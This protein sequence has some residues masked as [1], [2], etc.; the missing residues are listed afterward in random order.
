MSN[1]DN[2]KLLLGIDIGTSSIK[3]S[4][5]DRELK[6]YYSNAVKYKYDT[7]N[8]DWTEINPAVWTD[9]IC[10][11]LLKIFKMPFSKSIKGICPTAQMHTLVFLNE[12]NAPIRKAIMWN[13]KRTKN[14]ITDLKVALGKKLDFKYNANIISTGS[15]LANLIWLKENE[16]NNFKRLKKICM[17]K[18]Y[19][20]TFL[21][22]KIATDFCDASVSCLMDLEK[23]K[24]SKKIC[25]YFGI[26]IGILPNI[27]KSTEQVGL[28][29]GNI[30][31]QLS[32]KETIPVFTGTGDN[33]ATV[34]ATKYFEKTKLVLSLGTSGVVLTENKHLSLSGKNI[35]FRYL[36]K[37]YILAQTSLSTGGRSFDWWVNDV[38]QATNY[39]NEQKFSSEKIINNEI[40]FLPYLS[41]EKYLYKNPNLTGT[42]YN[43]SINDNRFD[44]NLAVLEGVIFTLK[45]LYL[46]SNNKKQKLDNLILLGGGSKSDV[47]ANIVANVFNTTVIRFKNSIEAV[48]GA[49][50]IG[51]LALHEEI[52][53]HENNEQKVKPKLKFIKHY[54]KKYK[55]FCSVSDK[56]N[57][58][59]STKKSLSTEI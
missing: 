11:E 29:K 36:E 31:Q 47:W 1:I 6:N 43:L 9:I 2:Q 17:C 45:S 58:L 54:Q 18:D 15:P 21:T 32:I 23:G 27:Q 39:N 53:I 24:W 42:F 26:D 20:N 10:T 5:V 57:E 49:A 30:C 22:D 35:L 3:F 44:L 28:L 52:C 13:D 4:V 19:I 34:L 48:T 55:Y 50:I 16:P 59:S 14:I 37:K 25:E 40:L 8:K 12:K 56:I 7:L 33:A 51:L 38:L 41:G 46:I